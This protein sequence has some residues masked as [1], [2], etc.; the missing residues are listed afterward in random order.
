MT[1]ATDNVSESQR[2]L[3]ELITA[4]DEETL[5]RVR[6][7]G[8]YEG[9]Q[10][11]E[12]RQR[13]QNIRAKCAQLADLPTEDE[14]P[15]RVAAAEQRVAEAE[16]AVERAKAN[17]ETARRTLSATRGLG[18]QRKQLAQAINMAAMNG[19]LAHIVKLA[20]R[21]DRARVGLTEGGE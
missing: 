10:I 2:D 6:A 9:Q 21:D 18:G 20:T 13:V 4:D 14:L 11:A 15:E 1:T 16:E 12:A 5:K 17:L 3:I 7:I 8:G 19:Q